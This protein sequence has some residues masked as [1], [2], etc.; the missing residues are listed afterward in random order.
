[1]PLVLSQ[2]SQGLDAGL[3]ACGPLSLG[4]LLLLRIP[5]RGDGQVQGTRDAR[6][7]ALASRMP[8]TKAL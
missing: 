2:S 1:M 5:W 3:G 4:P 8:R 6:A 7:R